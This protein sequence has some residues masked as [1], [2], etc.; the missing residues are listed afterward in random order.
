MTMKPFCPVNVPLEHLETHN[1]EYGSR[2]RDAKASFK[3]K[4]CRFSRK[5]FDKVQFLK[6][7]DVISHVDVSKQPVGRL[8]LFWPRN[9]HH[10]TLIFRRDLP[11]KKRK[12]LL[13][14]ASLSS[15]AGR[16]LL[17]ELPCLIRR[18]EKEAKR[19]KIERNCAAPKNRSDDDKISNVIPGDLPQLP[20]IP[21]LP[22]GCILKAR[23]G[24]KRPEQEKTR[25]NRPSLNKIN[26]RVT[27]EKK[28]VS[29]ELAPKR[30][31][32]NGNRG[33]KVG[34]PKNRVV[35]NGI[36]KEDKKLGTAYVAIEKLQL[37]HCEDCEQI[38]CSKLKPIDSHPCFSK[39][40]FTQI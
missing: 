27:T 23:R 34:R 24:I 31:V 35:R 28:A 30:K 17:K 29:D 10:K 2:Y 19:L 20:K 22:I 1:R 18:E 33:R 9:D 8:R 4:E 39:K 36:V 6:S 32:A 38:L 14:V 3:H 12:E 37:V 5:L 11:I 21:K 7:L 13:S 16:R 15:P 26:K 25:S 40:T